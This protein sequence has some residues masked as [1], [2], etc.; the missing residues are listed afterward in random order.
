MR[1]ICPYLSCGKTEI[2]MCVKSRC[3][4]WSR[5]F[6]D[7][8]IN[9]EAMMKAEEFGLT[10]EGLAELRGT[11]KK[12]TTDVGWLDNKVSE[13]IVENIKNEEEL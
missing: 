3:K 6:K 13:Q 12:E 4:M 11:K 5:K 9:I 1:K 8:W 2:R 10:K 7:C